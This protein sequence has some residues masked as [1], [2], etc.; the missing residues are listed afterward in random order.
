MAEVGDKWIKNVLW[1]ELLEAS[2][3]YWRTH[4]KENDNDNEDPSDAIVNDRIVQHKLISFEQKINPILYMEEKTPLLFG[5]Y[6]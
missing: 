4:V 2:E 6:F 1:S 5:H 3:K